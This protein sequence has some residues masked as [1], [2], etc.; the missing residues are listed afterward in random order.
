MFK[1]AFSQGAEFNL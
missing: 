1:N